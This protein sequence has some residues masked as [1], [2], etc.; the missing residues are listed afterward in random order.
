MIDR[1]KFFAAIRAGKLLGPTLTQ[2]EVD[3]CNAILDAMDGEPVA[4]TAY[5]FATAYKETAHSM[6]PIDEMGGD[7]YFFRMYDPHGNRPGVAAQLGN[8]QPGDGARFHGR[9]YVQLT[10]RALYARAGAK[11]D[12]DL[13]GN[14]ELAKRPDVAASVMRRGMD[15]GWFTGRSFASYLP[16]AGRAELPAFTAARHIINGQDCA[17]E[18]AGYAMTFQDALS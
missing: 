9:G 13:V 14:P 16:S 18:I 6:Q 15:S 10:G 1:S 5:A 8:A 2:S 7:G 17:A 11:L 4:F 3:G 12:V